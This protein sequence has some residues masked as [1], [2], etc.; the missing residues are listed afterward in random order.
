MAYKNWGGFPIHF[1]IFER[2]GGGLR[3]I[4]SKY[5]GVPYKKGRLKWLKGNSIKVH[6]RWLTKRGRLT[7]ANTV[8]KATFKADRAAFTRASTVKYSI[9]SLFLY[10]RAILRVRT[11]FWAEQ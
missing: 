3:K 4:L 5:M 1:F 6:R 11:V 9:F 10:R 8:S 7:R 2:E